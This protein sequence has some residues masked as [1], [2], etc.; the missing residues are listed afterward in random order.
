MA[1][2]LIPDETHTRLVVLG[3]WPTPVGQP[4]L[5]QAGEARA[6][7]D[8]GIEYVA[9]RGAAA[10]RG[11]VVREWERL[12]PLIVEIGSHGK[13]GAIW[14]TDGATS[15]GWWARLARTY[16]P[17]LMVLLACESSAQDK[18]NVAD[19]LFAAGVAAV[20]SV[21]ATLG[22]ADAVLFAEM[23]YQHLAAGDPLAFA[24]ERAKL[25]LS[26]P[27]AEMVRVRERTPDGGRFRRQLDPTPHVAATG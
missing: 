9:L 22:D 3:I 19:A 23:L 17:R 21:D 18:L 11:G 26:D 8:A 7:Y 27:G 16:P 4:L 20:V 10:T 5:D 15:P 12:H 1:E 25:V 6:L 13:A 24:V 2:A 14:L